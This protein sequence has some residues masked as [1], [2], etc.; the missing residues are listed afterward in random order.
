MSMGLSTDQKGAIAELAIAKAAIARRIGVYRPVGEGGRY[1]LIFDFGD[2]LDRVQCKWAPLERDVITVRVYSNRRT[3]DGSRRRRYA[4]GE[5]DAVA[6]YCPELDRCFYL[7]AAHVAARLQIS[8]RIARSRNNQTHGI[9]WADGFA[10][11]GL[12]S[13]LLGP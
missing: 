6:A 10:F 2:R 5:I 1:D 13:A 7:P 12:Q 11:E 9:N 8:L 4:I 3:A